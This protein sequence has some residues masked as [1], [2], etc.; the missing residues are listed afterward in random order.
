[1]DHYEDGAIV[2]QLFLDQMETRCTGLA[3]FLAVSM[4]RTFL[5]DKDADWQARSNRGWTAEKRQAM[6]DQCSRII[7]QPQWRDRILGGLRSE[8]EQEFYEADR[9]AA[10]L[11]MDAWPFHWD[12]LQ[13][14]PLQAARWF[15]VME[16]CNQE[17]VAEVVALAESTLPLD[18]VATG[19]AEEIG[20]G[21]GYETH[22]CL[23]FILQ[24]LG[25]FPG[26]G[27]R[28]IEAGLKSPVIRNRNLALKVLSEWGKEKWPAN[29]ERLLAD[30]RDREPDEK[31][32]KRIDN[33][34]AGRPLESG[35]GSALG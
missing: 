8:D 3:Q 33:V 31:V 21:P 16:G 15:G 32:R 11:E 22:G 30:A 1:V 23:D 26:H 10:V 14:Q 12:R 25:R 13:K 6:L 18:S 35:I 9:A 34:L 4:I 24:E 20:L 2:V 17:R 7:H 19:P 27:I 5:S 29:V 28:L